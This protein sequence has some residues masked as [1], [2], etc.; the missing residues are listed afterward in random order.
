MRQKIIWF[1]NDTTLD[2]VRPKTSLSK[3]SRGIIQLL[4]YLWKS[5][6]TKGSA[7]YVKLV[8][9]EKRLTV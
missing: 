3:I 6:C 7:N 1:M 4:I 5:R 8:V 9:K 2:E